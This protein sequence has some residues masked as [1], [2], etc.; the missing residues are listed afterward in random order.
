DPDVPGATQVRREP[1]PAWV[2]GAVLSLPAALMLCLGLLGL[3]RHSVWRDEAASLVAARRSLPELW[4]MLTH[5]ETVHAVYYTLLHGWLLLGSG[6]AW[7]RVPSVLAMTVA[8]GLVGVIAA[9]LVSVPVGLVAGLLFAVNPSASY[10][11]QEARST[12]LVAACALL[13]TWFLLRAL[14]RGSGWWT[15]YAITCTFLVG[16]NLLALLVPLAHAIT[17]ICWRRRRALAPLAAASAP[18][19]LVAVVL[20]VAARHQPY[21]IGWIPKPG[22]ASIRDFAHLALGPNVPVALLVS[23]LALAGILRSRGAAERR[24]V[25]LAL[26]MATVPTAALLAVSLVQ[27]IFVARYVFPSVAAV[28][29]LAALGVVRLGGVVAGRTGRRAVGLVA[30]AAVLVVATGGLGTQRLERTA[31]SR[32]DDLAGAARV[33]ASAARPGDAMLFLPS[34]R[35]IVALVYPGAFKDVHDVGLDSEP[36]RAG[37]L[38]GR[39]LPVGVTLQNLSASSR[40]WAIGRPGLALT[41]SERDARIELAMLD[42]DFVAVERTGSHGVGITLYVRRSDSS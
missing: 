19:L 7:A 25:V 26:P 29:L 38:T 2:D 12:A 14:Q 18:G 9:R 41:P 20:V 32:P 1:R 42:R 22:G 36:A 10:Y 16:L 34:N 23:L 30:A 11:A 5:V 33:V 35:G 8:A 21:Q 27:P 40:V 24:L 4:S 39:P 37:D 31:A 17:L 6:E 3:D 13:A 28:A 15:A